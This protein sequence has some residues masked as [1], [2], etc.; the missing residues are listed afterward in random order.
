MIEVP[1]VEGVVGERIVVADESGRGRGGG[2]GEDR[3]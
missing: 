3:L 1:E 2:D